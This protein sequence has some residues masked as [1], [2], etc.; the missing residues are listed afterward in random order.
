MTTEDWTNEQLDIAIQA[1]YEIIKHLS[2]REE[3]ITKELAE[4][5]TQVEYLTGQ[6]KVLTHHD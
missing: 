4:M 6:S 5:K 1:I 3:Q 2:E